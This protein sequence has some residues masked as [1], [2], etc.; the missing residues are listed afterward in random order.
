MPDDSLQ[1]WVYHVFSRGN[2][3]T[4]DI[5]LNIAA[6]AMRSSLSSTYETLCDI[7]LAIRSQASW[8]VLPS[9]VT[10]G[11]IEHQGVRF[12]VYDMYTS[13]DENFENR[14]FDATLLATEGMDNK[15]YD[16]WLKARRA[17]HDVE[18]KYFRFSEVGRRWY[19]IAVP[20]EESS[21]G[22]GGR[23]LLPK[24]NED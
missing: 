8:P 3:G 6:D 17:A 5:Q 2:A 14:V 15:S 10:P 16:T 20:E 7:A 23:P 11:V 22:P 18:I 21:D 24:V 9:D 13:G 12:T 19:D 4:E 1:Y